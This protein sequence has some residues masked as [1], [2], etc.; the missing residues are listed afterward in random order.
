MAACAAVASGV[1]MRILLADD[2][3]DLAELLVEILIDA[4]EPLPTF[5]V[6]HNGADA[7]ALGLA[8]LHDVAVLDIDMP[9]MS[10]IEVAQGMQARLGL[11]CP[12]MIALTGNLFRNPSQ[13]MNQAFDHA[14]GKPVDIERLLALIR[15]A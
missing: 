15:A 12:V 3:V 10:G 13:G 4:L 9:S 11:A 1:S 5:H 7:L 2:N 8:H 14:L 6:A